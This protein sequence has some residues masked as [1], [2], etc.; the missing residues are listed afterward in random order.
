MKR[1]YQHDYSAKKPTVFDKI[2]HLRKARTY[3]VEI[4]E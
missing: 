3:E 2:E 1:G 4:L